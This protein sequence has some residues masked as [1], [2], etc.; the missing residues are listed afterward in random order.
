MMRES[1]IAWFCPI[2]DMP[3]W[4]F[5][6]RCVWILLQIIAAYCLANEVSP[7]FYQRF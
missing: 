3:L 6:L 7:F 2:P 1:I 4:M 5:Y